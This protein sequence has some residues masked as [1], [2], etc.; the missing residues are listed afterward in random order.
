MEEQL[1]IAHTLKEKTN[2][3]TRPE[4]D[5]EHKLKGNTS[6]V[7]NL[8]GASNMQEEDVVRMKNETVRIKKKS[9]EHLYEL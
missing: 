3:A 1:A 6:A 8:A 4:V 5:Y 2:T 7:S 9:H